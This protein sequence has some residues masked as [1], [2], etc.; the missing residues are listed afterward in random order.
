[1]KTSQVGK[2]CEVFDSTPAFLIVSAGWSIS[3][4]LTSSP[5]PT[6]TGACNSPK[7]PTQAGF[8]ILDSLY[9]LPYNQYGF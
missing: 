9:P 1:M 8:L 2:T 5:T 3:T 4:K 7:K 6:T